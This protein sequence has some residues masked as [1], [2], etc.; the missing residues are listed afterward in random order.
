M[1]NYQLCSKVAKLNGK[2]KKQAN[3]CVVFHVPCFPAA[4]PPHSFPLSATCQ[5]T[6]TKASR[7]LPSCG[8]GEAILFPATCL[9]CQGIPGFSLCP[10]RLPK[11][12]SR[13]CPCGGGP[14]QAADR[15][16]WAVSGEMRR[17]QAQLILPRPMAVGEGLQVLF[18][19][20]RILI[21]LIYIFRLRNKG[22]PRRARWGLMVGQGT[23]SRILR[24][25]LF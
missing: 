9:G 12:L 5:G 23:L 10:V 6:F 16:L 11:P 18:Y 17:G 14:G 20:S 7:C 3:L 25:W 1:I 2:E 15:W 24:H 19:C 13:V 22:L 8:P 21:C 4:H